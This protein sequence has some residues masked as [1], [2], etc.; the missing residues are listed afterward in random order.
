MNVIFQEDFQSFHTKVYLHI[1]RN[2][3]EI[4]IG[5]DGKNLIEQRI[6]E[7]PDGTYIALKPLF[8]FPGH[9]K[10]N[11]LQAFL[12]AANQNSLKTINEN[13]LEGKIIATEKHLNDMQEFSKKL[14]DKIISITPPATN[15]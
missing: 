15:Q 14:L 4:F 9:L 12:D 8:V 13:L 3:E 6:S 5:F 2:N 7:N 1:F 11:I 10:G